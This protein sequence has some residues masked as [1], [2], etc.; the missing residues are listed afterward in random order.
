MQIIL[1]EIAVEIWPLGLGILIILGILVG[2][3]K[4][5]LSYVICFLIFS[6]Y[7]LLALDRAFFPIAISGSYADAMRQYPSYT[8]MVNLAPFN[9]DFSEAP[10][11]V[12]RQIFQN[13]LLT[14]PFG[15]GISF[16]TPIRPRDFRWLA[17]AVGVGIEGIQF[18]VSLLLGYYYHVIDINDAML[19]ALGVLIGFLIFYGFARVFLWATKRLQFGGFAGYVRTVAS[20]VQSPYTQRVSIN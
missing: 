11:L 13:V 17:P 4:R 14:V 20:K 18:I 9:F 10:E 3:R 1:S 8:P 6:V 15:F 7:L 16:I 2:Y 19:N 12:F 5:S